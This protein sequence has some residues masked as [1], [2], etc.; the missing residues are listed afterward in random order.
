MI[1]AASQTEGSTRGD[2]INDIGLV[3]EDTLTAMH[4]PKSSSAES[5]EDKDDE[6]EEKEAWKDLIDAMERGDDV[7]EKFSDVL[8][9][10]WKSYVSTKREDGS[11]ALH[12]AA[13]R[14]RQQQESLLINSGGTK[15]DPLDIWGCT[16]LDD[17]C[18]EQSADHTRAVRLFLENSAVPKVL[19]NAGYSPLSKAAAYG[20]ADIVELLL[21]KDKSI[22]EFSEAEAEANSGWTP[23]HIAV[24]GAS[25]KATRIMQILLKYGAKLSIVDDDGW[26]PLMPATVAGNDEILRMLLRQES[27]RQGSQLETRDRN[28]MTPLMKAATD[29][30][31]A[32]SREDNTEPDDSGG[33]TALHL[34]ILAGHTTIPRLLLNSGA[35][36]KV[37]RKDGKVALGLVA[38][39][40]DM[41]MI[42][43]IMEHYLEKANP[44]KDST[45]EKSKLGL[46]E[47]LFEA[48]IWAASR[49]QRHSFALNVMKVRLT[50]FVRLKSDNRE[51]SALEWAA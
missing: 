2:T 31:W 10:P 16:P 23:L 42:G 30:Y 8:R 12:I 22:L 47:E 45:L 32:G 29:G 44:A 11:T 7:E 18:S 27:N 33:E 36:P 20:N 19:D 26:T 38:Q 13:R 34:A 39:S 43:V 25:D 50:S 46:S 37:R 40:E 9:G 48:L 28:G 1:H 17:A 49:R 3:P 21:Q 24:S 15:I 6:E 5:P 4:V 14:G 41:Q 35:D 51:W